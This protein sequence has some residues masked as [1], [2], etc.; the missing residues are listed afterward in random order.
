[1]STPSPLA[2]NLSNH[3]VVYEKSF[4]TSPNTNISNTYICPVKNLES[5]Y[6]N[7]LNS[8][9]IQIDG[10]KS[11]E[12][13]DEE[14]KNVMEHSDD[15]SSK[16]KI[17]NNKTPFLKE[18]GNNAIFQCMQVKPLEYNYYYY[19]AI[20]VPKHCRCFNQFPNQITPNRILSYVFYGY[21]LISSTFHP[22][23]IREDEKKMG[24]IKPS[25]VAEIRRDMIKQKNSRSKTAEILDKNKEYS[26][27]QEDEVKYLSLKFGKSSNFLKKS[28]IIEVNVQ[29]VEKEF[30]LTFPKNGILDKTKTYINYICT[31]YTLNINSDSEEMDYLT[32]K[33]FYE[34][35]NEMNTKIEIAKQISKKDVKDTLLNRKRNYPKKISDKKSRRKMTKKE[36]MNQKNKNKKDGEKVS[37]YLNNIEI[38]DKSLIYFPF[39]EQINNDEIIKVSFLEGI[40][41]ENKLF[42]KNEKNSLFREKIPNLNNYLFRVTYYKKNED[43]NGAYIYMLK[44]RGINILYLIN[45]YYSLIKKKVL[46]INKNHYSHIKFGKSLE[47]NNKIGNLVLIC[48]DLV[49]KLKKGL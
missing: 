21:N 46:K 19:P 22:E 37:I 26:N 5:K 6:N 44:I 32:I 34:G 30:N 39:C 23:N 49:T 43:K 7:I 29:K 14:V 15:F 8:K 42:H 2:L 28:E 45:Y 31:N 40:I 48:N 41:L 33:T 16:D 36:K 12:K 9:N 1:M 17:V 20:F 35:C 27:F 10:K 4:N 11:I 18:N 47:E 3:Q 38:N 13:K 25:R 24:S